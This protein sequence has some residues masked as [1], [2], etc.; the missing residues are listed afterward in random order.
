MKVT[1]HPAPGHEDRRPQT[2]VLPNW[3]LLMMT[4]TPAGPLE[5]VSLPVRSVAPRIFDVIVTPGSR[6]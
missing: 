1:V 2:V 3:L 5:H 4:S 6:P